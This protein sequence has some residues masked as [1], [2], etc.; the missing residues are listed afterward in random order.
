ML[1]KVGG[2][3]LVSCGLWLSACAAAPAAPRGLDRCI[4]IDRW[5]FRSAADI[6]RAIDRC[7]QAGFAAVLFQV[8]GNG[9]VCYP[10]AHEVWSERFG[11]RDPGFDPLAV[12]VRAA[13]DRGMQLH[14]WV[15]VLPGW[16]GVDEPADDRQLWR[17]RRDWFL[18]R[19]DGGFQ[20]RQAGKYLALNPCRAEVRRYLAD[21]C[22]EIAA[23]YEVDGIHLDYVRFPDPEG[24]D[25]DDLGADPATLA[26]FTGST[27]RTTNDVLALR[28][29][30]TRAVTDL[31]ATVRGALR[32]NGRPVLLS[33]AV[34]ADVDKAR[35]QLRQ[36]WP[37]WCRRGLVDAVLPM[38]YTEQDGLFA[39]RTRA[40][41][42]AAGT[43]PV[44]AGIGVYKHDS[45]AQSRRQLEAA[46]RA[47][48][49]GVGVFNY[50]SLFGASPEVRPELQADLQQSVG[51][52]L[53]AT[54]KPKR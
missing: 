29:F 52:W 34:I 21:L 40:A 51:A 19:R 26:A 36:D 50:R 14:A 22:A 20:T 43:V 42:E 12:A 11:F 38:N 18:Q 24:D 2:V 15:N 35:R 33:A 1:R 3:F 13:H 27:G 16:V 6:E 39:A 30:Q 23:N 9:T 8:R 45:G 7:Q 44:I 54:A 17:S 41:V 53:E 25:L 32:T 4:W 5:D 28:A 31:V 46:R 37:D 49:R 48:A 10:S 47:G